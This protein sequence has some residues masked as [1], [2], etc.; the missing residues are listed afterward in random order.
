METVSEGQ[1]GG[2]L[3]PLVGTVAQCHGSGCLKVVSSGGST[4][5]QVNKP[6]VAGVP[7]KGRGSQ[8]YLLWL[9]DGGPSVHSGCAPA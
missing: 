8:T 6:V 3:W 2:S 4:A 5:M 9:I 1:T 7:L